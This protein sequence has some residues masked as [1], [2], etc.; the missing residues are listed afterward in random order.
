MQISA[1]L[2]NKYINGIM[3][4]FCF[5]TTVLQHKFLRL[6]LVGNFFA[7]LDPLDA[8]LNIVTKMRVGIF[9]HTKLLNFSS[10]ASF[11]LLCVVILFV[12]VN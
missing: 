8:A 5:L 10:I 3:R 4:L 9:S 6:N 11:Y 7:G 1:Y 12:I 2:Y